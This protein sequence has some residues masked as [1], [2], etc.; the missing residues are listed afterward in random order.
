M[1]RL[2]M[3]VV[4]LVGW[5]A[6]GAGTYDVMFALR[7][8]GTNS[9]KAQL[10]YDFGSGWTWNG[11][12]IFTI[13]AGQTV[14]TYQASYCPSATYAFKITESNG[15]PLNPIVY[16]QTNS[17]TRGAQWEEALGLIEFGLNSAPQTK[18][19]HRV[20]RNNGTR[21]VSA[22]FKKN[23]VI[24]HQAFLLPGEEAEYTFQYVENDVLQWGS[25]DTS[26]VPVDGDSP[27]L[28]KL[29]NWNTEIDN[30]TTNPDAPQTNNA[31]VGTRPPLPDPTGGDWIPFVGTNTIEVV[32]EAFSRKEV[33]DSEADK[34]LLG[35]AQRIRMASESMSNIVQR[36]YATGQLTSARIEATL[37]RGT[38]WGNAWDES[39]GMVGTFSNAVKSVEDV[40]SIPSFPDSGGSKSPFMLTL[41]G[42]ELDLDPEHIAPGAMSMV[43]TLISFVAW[44]L[45]AI[46][47]SKAIFEATKTYA[48]AQTGG[49]PDLG[50][51]GTN[52]LGYSVAA[53]IP[54]ALTFGWLT[55]LALCVVFFYDE[56]SA[57]SFGAIKTKF[58]SIP[59]P[60]G[61][62]YL[63]A[64]TIPVNLLISFTVCR[65]LLWLFVAKAVAVAAT[66]SRFLY[67]K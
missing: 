43:Y 22:F 49:V 7:N 39:S 1:K 19:L 27:V 23:G 64:N 54:L 6:M 4:V 8:T 25:E 44:L 24:V 14:N 28:V 57:A 61:T 29:T 16:T 37:A 51:L 65:I 67:G 62:K 58:E 31:T 59:I 60:V 18:Y 47:G 46:E 63:F 13:Q 66:I 52:W 30:G 10:G 11:T 50:I 34:D 56:S 12:W 45:L 17:Y 40:L 20:V 33:L 55:M 26:W 36:S 53:I 42:H 15:V 48:S 2:L 38:N 9:M 41:A 5:S 3:L 21:P 35:E 32:K